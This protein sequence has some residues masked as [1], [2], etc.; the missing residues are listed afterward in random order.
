MTVSKSSVSIQAVSYNGKMVF[1]IPSAYTF[2][3]SPESQNE[4]QYYM[5]VEVLLVTQV[6]N[7]FCISSSFTLA[8]NFRYVYGV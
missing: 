3:V 2:L 8:F 5:P 7:C 1:E 6:Q 4:L